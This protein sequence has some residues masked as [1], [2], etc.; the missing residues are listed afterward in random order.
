VV[1]GSKTMSRSQGKR[2]HG[3]ARDQALLTK[4]GKLQWGNFTSLATPPPWTIHH[5]EFVTSSIHSPLLTIATL[6]V[7]K[8]TLKRL[9]TLK[10]EHEDLLLNKVIE[11]EPRN[12][13]TLPSVT[14]QPHQSH[15]ADSTASSWRC[16]YSYFT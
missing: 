15:D 4:S 12:S 2:V 16:I 6:E 14:R 10:I 13:I 11:L 9:Q 8:Q 5:E 7:S 3:N 1:A